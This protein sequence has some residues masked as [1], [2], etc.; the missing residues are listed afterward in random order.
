MVTYGRLQDNIANCKLQNSLY[1][2]TFKTLGVRDLSQKYMG[3][4]KFLFKGGGGGVRLSLLTL[5]F[6]DLGNCKH[7]V[8]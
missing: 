8:F 5:Y 1:L 4:K 6:G 2:V 3:D 7:L